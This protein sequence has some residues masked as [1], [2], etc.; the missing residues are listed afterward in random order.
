MRK[1]IDCPLDLEYSTLT[2]RSHTTGRVP[3]PSCMSLGLTAPVWR[4]ASGRSRI[5]FKGQPPSAPAITL[6]VKRGHKQVRDSALELG[7]PP[8]R[9]P[10]A[11]ATG[12]SPNS[13]PLRRAHGS[14]ASAGK[15]VIE[16]QGN[17]SAL[18]AQITEPRA[19]AGAPSDDRT[20]RRRADGRSSAPLA[21]V[22][23]ARSHRRRSIV[24]AGH[25][26]TAR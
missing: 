23:G 18:L 13:A 24:V 6:S 5:L 20:D 11:A 22:P 21:R 3:A 9:R 26:A 4:R 12:K 14:R 2:E 8:G 15:K 19:R 17:V 7:R 25:E 1:A 16:I 10:P